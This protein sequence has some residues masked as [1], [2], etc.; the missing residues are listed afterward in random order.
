MIADHASL[1]RSLA[2]L[3]SFSRPRRPV[4]RC[5]MCSRELADQ[6]RHLLEIA[7]QRVLCACEACALLFSADV[8][9]AKYR[10]IPQRTR[11]LADFRLSDAQW[12]SLLVPINMAFFFR[13]TPR[14]RT[15]AMY[16]SPAGPTESLLELE[17]WNEIVDQNPVL[18]TLEPDVEALLVNRIGRMIAQGPQTDAQEPE[19]F[20][21]PIDECYRLVG[22]I[23]A[24]WRGLSGGKEVWERIDAFFAELRSR[25]RPA[26]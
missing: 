15:V 24:S 19:Y 16:P 11:F 3:R 1:N 21:V 6:H 9:E 22:V 25:G 2:A 12:D 10:R 8:A 23:R 26:K 7:N 4:P 13:S 20:L 5:E 14:K 18:Q 17:S